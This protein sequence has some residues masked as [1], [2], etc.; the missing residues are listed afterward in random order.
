MN[1][2]IKQQQKRR[3]RVR[4][5]ILGTA[6]RPRLSVYRS[7][8]YI[9]AQII[10]D[11]KRE[12]LVGLSSKSLKNPKVSPTEEARL[13]GE[14]IAKIAA[15]K[16]IKKVVFDRGSYQFHG[17]VKALAEGAKKGGLEF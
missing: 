6:N 16:E 11:V 14:K 17:R 9:N 13:L 7:N 10:D 3:V 8:R 5:K 1:D 12:T 4:G 2:K 15:K